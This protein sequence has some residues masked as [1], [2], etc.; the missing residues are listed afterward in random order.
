MGVINLATQYS[1]Q[2]D[3]A[4]PYKSYTRIPGTAKF[5]FIGQR[6]VK[7]YSIDNMKM[8]NFK[9][10]GDNRFG[11]VE[12]IGDSV[13]EMTVTK[14]RS[15]TGTIDRGNNTQQKMIKKAGESLS[16]QKEEVLNPEMDT[17]NLSVWNNKAVLNGAIITAQLTKDN[18]YEMFLKAQAKL[19]NKRVPK[20][21][22]VCFIA[23]D[24]SSLFKRN[25]EVSK[26]TETAQKWIVEGYLGKVD[27]V[28]LIE[29]PDS[30][31]PANVKMIILH[32]KCTTLPVQLETYRILTEVQGYDGP[33][34]EG[35]TIY[36]CFVLNKKKDGLVAIAEGTTGMHAVSTDS[37][38]DED[39]NL[40]SASLGATFLM[41]DLPGV[42]TEDKITIKYKLGTSAITVPAIGATVSGYT[43][44][45]NGEIATESNTHYSLVGL[46][47]NNKVVF[48]ESGEIVKKTA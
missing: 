8:N 35:R 44:Y 23:T 1:T 24:A 41:Y 42:L 18:I 32:P 25:N 2:I 6:T 10:S 27:G 37:Y 43:N 38:Y 13:Q 26:D 14:D 5:E 19:S 21:G 15:F 48:A 40:V 39:D 16:Q 36:D 9:R 45:T 20:T 12:D 7:V 31:L 3:K 34:I 11:K 46:D 33:V 4:W 29:V 22:R 17:Y 28:H 30:Y 47:K